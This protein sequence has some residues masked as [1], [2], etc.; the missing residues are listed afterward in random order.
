MRR[1]SVPDEAGG[2][3]GALIQP[4]LKRDEIQEIWRRLKDG[5]KGIK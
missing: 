2:F 4:Q 5:E 3:E 1:H